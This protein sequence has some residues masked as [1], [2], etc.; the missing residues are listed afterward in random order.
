MTLFYLILIILFVIGLTMYILHKIF[1]ETPID[2]FDWFSLFSES[3][4]I[5]SIILLFIIVNWHILHINWYEFFN[6]KVICF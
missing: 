4:L 6:Y 2:F 1:H 5:D 3:I